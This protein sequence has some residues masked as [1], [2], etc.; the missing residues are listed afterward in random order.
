MAPAHEFSSIQL[1]SDS[2]PL[3]VA[4]N[5]G[6]SFSL[7]NGVTGITAKPEPDS[8]DLVFSDIAGMY[9]LVPA[10][11][12]GMPR[13]TVFQSDTGI[14]AYTLFDYALADS[15]V[16]T[17]GWQSRPALLGNS[18]YWKKTLAGKGL[19]FYV[20]TY[21][22]A[23]ARILVQPNADSTLVSRDTSSGD[24]GIGYNYITVTCAY[25]EN[26]NLVYSRMKPVHAIRRSN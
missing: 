22:G 23:Y 14:P 19:V 10:N 16:E 21:N 26:T 9:A 7:D 17:T 20:R 2:V 4:V 8:V 3:G 1:Y 18:P 15:V 11:L 24:L 13:T 6:L 5:T 12:E 25:Q